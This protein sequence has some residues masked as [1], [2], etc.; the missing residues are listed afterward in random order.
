MRRKDTTCVTRRTDV[1]RQHN[2]N[3]SLHWKNEVQRNAGRDFYFMPNCKR[4]CWPGVNG[5]HQNLLSDDIFMSC[6]MTSGD[7]MSDL[8]LGGSSD[9]F[10][11][12]FLFCLLFSNMLSYNRMC[13]SIRKNKLFLQAGYTASGISLIHPNTFLIL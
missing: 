3:A 5:D 8:L 2:I 11:D 6:Q 9:G 13:K 10:C 4:C 1:I 7:D 12:G